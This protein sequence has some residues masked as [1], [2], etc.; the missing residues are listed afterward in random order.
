VKHR[1]ED[2]TPPLFAAKFSGIIDVL[3]GKHPTHHIHANTRA[4]WRQLDLAD[5]ARDILAVLDEVGEP[6]TDRDICGRLGSPDMNYARP[7]IT[8]MVQDGVLVE[9]GDVTC[10]V[11]GR[12]V[13]TVWFTA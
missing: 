5:R 11:T 2:P 4:S 1:S 10:P 8:H 3:K 6:M 13:R 7:S 12:T 9:A